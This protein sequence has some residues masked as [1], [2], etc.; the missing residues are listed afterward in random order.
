MT[1]DRRVA[2]YFVA[3]P[4]Q[5]LAAR[6]IARRYERGA[7]Q[8]LVWYQPGVEPIVRAEEWDAGT[9]MPWPRWH[10]L[11]GPFGRIRRLRA[12]VREVSGLVGQCDVLHLHSAVFDT[13][14]INYFLQ[15]LP[16]TSGATQMHARILP[17][18]I[19]NVRR[20][21]LSLGKRFLMSFRKLRR[22]VAPELKYS[23]FAGDRIGSDAPFC[24]RIYVL[25][26]F[27]HEYPASKVVALDRLADAGPNEPTGPSGRALVIGQPLTGAG[28]LDAGEL[29]GL[30]QRMRDWLASRGIQ[31]VIYRGH[32]KDQRAEL[33]RPGDIIPH[34]EEPLELWLPRQRFDV[35]VGVRSTVL[36]F[37]R[38]IYGPDTDVR[39][40]GWNVVRFKSAAERVS[41]EKAF[42]S[43][44]VQMD[45]YE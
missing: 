12:N 25:P 9:Y 10:P 17:D 27:P 1:A 8:I 39:A 43:A 13:E 2:V 33:S 40:F 16:R 3:S 37:A 6:Q 32:P 23:A 44:G 35:V 30:T 18:G 19:L 36:M 20:Y 28:L 29:E 41:M 34:L 22:L 31:E 14:A 7:R 26:G 42:R 24:D 11:P 21:P 15:A 5:Y 45:G 38:Q 4:L